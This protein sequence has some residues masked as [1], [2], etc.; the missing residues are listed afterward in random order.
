MEEFSLGFDNPASLRGAAT[1][2]RPTLQNPRGR[3][4]GHSIANVLPLPGRALQLLC[5]QHLH[6]TLQARNNRDSAREKAQT[7]PW[8]RRERTSRDSAKKP[9]GHSK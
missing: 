5:V 8:G 6:P 4:L 9:R 7:K 3:R 2:S 1:A